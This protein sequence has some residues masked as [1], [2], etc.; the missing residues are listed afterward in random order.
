MDALKQYQLLG[1]LLVYLEACGLESDAATFDTALRMLSDI[2]Q[3]A[4]ESQEF[5]WLLER[6]PYYFRI[7]EDALPK[8]APPFQRGSIGYYAHGS[9]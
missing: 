2:P 9:S 4:A 3:S 6:I 7:A 5:D 8:V 1:R